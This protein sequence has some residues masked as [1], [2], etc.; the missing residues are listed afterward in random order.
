MYPSFSSVSLESSKL[1]P[2]ITLSLSSLLLRLLLFLLRRRV[3]ARSVVL[4][5]AVV[6]NSSR[7]AVV[8]ISYERQ[9]FIKNQ[10][11]RSVSWALARYSSE[12]TS[13]TVLPWPD[14]SLSP[15]L[16][17]YSRPREIVR[18]QYKKSRCTGHTD[19]HT[20][21]RRHAASQCFAGRISL[22]H[23]R[24]LYIRGQENFLVHRPAWGDYYFLKIRVW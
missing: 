15:T 9:G 7:P 18:W 10:T 4:A 14:P 16:I 8:W 20:H 6:V 22:G 21:T 17:Q 23:L 13:C 11:H 1:Y 19:I 12:V 2:S 3:K 24:V 5:G